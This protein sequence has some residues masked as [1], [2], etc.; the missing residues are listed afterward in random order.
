MAVTGRN[1]AGTHLQDR[2][3]SRHRGTG[4]NFTRCE[5]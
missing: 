1:V 5:K 2:K 3:G 4:F